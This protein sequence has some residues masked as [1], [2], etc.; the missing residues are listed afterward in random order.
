LPS[1]YREDVLLRDFEE[2]TIGKSRCVWPRARPRRAGF[3][4]LGR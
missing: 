2:L 4:G 3:T 1:I